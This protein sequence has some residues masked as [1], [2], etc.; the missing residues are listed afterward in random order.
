MSLLG[1]KLSREVADV[2]GL[3]F[4]RL[5][6]GCLER[7]QSRLAHHRDEV[8]AFFRP[9]AGKVGLRSAQDVHRRR[10]SHRAFLLSIKLILPISNQRTYV[11]ISVRRRQ[12]S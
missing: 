1:V 6:T 9:V 4:L 5:D 10:F 2:R 12:T 7:A 11:R 8:L 3:N